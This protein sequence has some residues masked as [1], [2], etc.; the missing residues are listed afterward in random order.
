MESIGYKGKGTSASQLTEIRKQRVIAQL[1]N[2]N[3]IKTR[4]TTSIPQVKQFRP[5]LNV[6]SQITHSLLQ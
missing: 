1:Y 6:Y 5:D 4:G 2:A 3:Q